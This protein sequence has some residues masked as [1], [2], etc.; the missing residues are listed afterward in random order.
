MDSQLKSPQLN[1]KC[2]TSVL[3]HFR[4]QISSRC[5]LTIEDDRFGLQTVSK[6]KLLTNVQCSAKSSSS[7][8]SRWERSILEVSHWQ[9]SSKIHVFAFHSNF[10]Q[11]RVFVVS[12]LVPFDHQFR[13]T[14]NWC[15]LSFPRKSDFLLT[16]SSCIF[17]SM[18][19]MEISK[20]GFPRTNLFRSHRKFPP[21][22]L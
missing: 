4:N 19:F 17:L 6:F 9:D 2:T 7:W 22:H 10:K 15:G 11:S 13:L 1:W 3:I 21:G 16:V 20:S 8:E 14:W 12:L 18:L 5:Q